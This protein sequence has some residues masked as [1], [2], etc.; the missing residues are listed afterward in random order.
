MFLGCIM[1]FMIWVG[2][3][4]KEPPEVLVTNPMNGQTVSGTVSITAEATDNKGIKNVEFYIDGVLSSATS[5]EPYSYSWLTTS[6]L[7]SSAHNIYAKAYD[8]SEN[9]GISSVISVMVSNGPALPTPSV[10]YQ[11]TTNNY[12]GGLSLTW[13]QIADA[14][15]YLIYADGICVDTVSGSTYTALVPAKKY[16]VYAY[17]SNNHSHP[18]VVNIAPVVTS[19]LDVWDYS[20]PDPSHPSGFGFYESGI[21]Q[22]YSVSDTTYWPMIDQYI[23]WLFSLISPDQHVPPYNG[24][25][26][27]TKNSLSTSFD[28]KDIADQ[29][30][31][32]FN[33]SPIASDS[34]YYLWIDP[35]NDGW[36]N[37]TD[38]FSKIK[39]VAINGLRVTLT[40]AYQPVHG[41]R[42]L[43]TP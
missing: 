27:F 18:G 9:E 33:Y 22:A 5:A 26:N 43:V 32:Y 13:D 40:L 17:R 38:H 39:V 15:G 8:A 12:G 14:D 7:D 1:C 29:P 31:Y 28:D 41:L 16:E 25:A 11:V 36:D 34:V 6:C 4:D 37:S 42:W 24:E 21:A 30:G 2:C 10:T 3:S 35:T 20:D 23:D 19:N